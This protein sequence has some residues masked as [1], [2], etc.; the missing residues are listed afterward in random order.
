MGHIGLGKRELGAISLNCFD[1]GPFEPFVLL[2]AQIAGC[3]K[4]EQ[5]PLADTD[6]PSGK[7]IPFRIEMEYPLTGGIGEYFMNGVQ[8]IVG[9][10][11]SHNGSVSG[12]YGM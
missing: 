9:C 2:Q 3:P 4:M 5:V 1:C 12:F 11:F 6:M 8:E 10:D 7:G